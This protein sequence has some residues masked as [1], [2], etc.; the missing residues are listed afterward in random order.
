[1]TK[2]SNLPIGVGNFP[3]EWLD[4][5]REIKNVTLSSATIEKEGLI[6]IAT[7]DEVNTGT[8]ATIAVTPATLAGAISGGASITQ[9]TPVATTSGST[10]SFTG[11]PAS[12]TT[13]GIV[14]GGVGQSA[15]S[16]FDIQIG[17]ASGLETTGY[18]GKTSTWTTSGS[19]YNRSSTT[20][21]PI[22]PSTIFTI[23]GMTY[24][25]LLWLIRKESGS[26]EWSISGSIANQTA[27]YNCFNIISVGTKTLSGELTQL[28]M[29]V[30]AGTFN[31]G[32]MNLLYLKG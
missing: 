25:G 30:S 15:A 2:L 23:A 20:S 26:N 22:I 21:F 17:T 28:Q 8:D 9:D 3:K 19:L 5:F 7:Q 31:A 27:S 1:M 32:Y 24:G 16:Y 6:R 14:F 13:V 18:I 12:V 4:W 29:T 10:V 11:I